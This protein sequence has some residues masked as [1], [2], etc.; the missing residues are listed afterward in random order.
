MSSV[1]KN[2]NS[3]S[4]TLLGIIYIIS[5]IIA[6]MHILGLLYLGLITI[7]AWLIVIVGF[8]YFVLMCIGDIG[9]RFYF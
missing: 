4:L 6:S 2:E 9:N 7:M 5:I 3:F 1:L 8:L